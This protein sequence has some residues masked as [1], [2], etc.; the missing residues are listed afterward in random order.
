MAEPLYFPGSDGTVN[1]VS[2]H[3]PHLIDSS[4]SL[5]PVALI[6][7]CAY[8]TNTI[9]LGQTRQDLPFTA[10]SQFKPTVL[11]GQLCYSLK[12]P[13]KDT[14]ETKTGKGD[15][16]V[17]IIDTGVQNTDETQNEESN[18]NPFALEH[19]GDNA[20]SARIY[21]NT[22]SSYTDFRP[23]SYALSALKKM[24]GT[25]SFLKQTDKE[26]KCR[27]ETLE[28]C[29]AKSYIDRVQNKCGCVPWA[30]SSAL[31]TKV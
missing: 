29:Q 26:K 11:K 14:V 8:Q 24:I 10:C 31:V 20:N 13:S 23:G 19:S 16:L 4:G 3:P 15:G 18:V 2:F 5:T 1:K 30:I 17:I 9:L 7:F 25:D 6:P 27:T 21:L 12:L 28:D 22:L